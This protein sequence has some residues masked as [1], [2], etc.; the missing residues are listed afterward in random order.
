MR[1][2]TGK[3]NHVQRF[4][5]DCQDAWDEAWGRVGVQQQETEGKGSPGTKVT[6]QIK[7]TS[8]GALMTALCGRNNLKCHLHSHRDST[9]I[10]RTIDTPFKRALHTKIPSIRPW[11]RRCLPNSQWKLYKIFFHINTGKAI[12]WGLS[13]STPNTGGYQTLPSYNWDTSRNNFSSMDMKNV[14]KER[15]IACWEHVCVHA[16]SYWL[17]GLDLALCLKL[18]FFHQRTQSKQNGQPETLCP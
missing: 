7:W 15:R 1:T 10:H 8:P 18:A 2:Q 13:K 5:G 16:Y 4:G 17:K 11:L 3:A 9:A 14:K 6:S 12:P